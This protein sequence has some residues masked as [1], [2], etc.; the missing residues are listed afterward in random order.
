M[1]GGGGELK[2]KSRE[3]ENRKAFWMSGG[4]L[5]RSCRE[6]PASEV[7]EIVAYKFLARRERLASS[8]ELWASEIAREKASSVR[9]FVEWES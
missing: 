8:K 6:I 9:R 1:V 2:R 4:E 7:D 3:G 5:T